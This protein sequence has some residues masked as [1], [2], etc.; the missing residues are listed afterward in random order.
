MDAMVDNGTK[1]P[2]ADPGRATESNPEVWFRES[3]KLAEDVAYAGPV[4][5][6]TTT[7]ALDRQ[8]ET[9]ARNTARSQAALAA[10]RLASL[11][12]SPLQ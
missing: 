4:H 11:I 8:Y 10:A 7:C 3:E 12:N 1:L 2:A 6:C 5:D 9:N